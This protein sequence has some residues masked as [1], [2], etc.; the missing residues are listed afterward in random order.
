M[1]YPLIFSILI[2]L[3]VGS[4]L[5]VA[6][7]RVH[8]GEPIVKGRS[9]CRSCEEP[10]DAKDLVPVLSYLH[11]KGRC[12]RCKSVISWQYPVIEVA[13]M[14]LFVVAYLRLEYLYQ[15]GSISE[16]LAY[17]LVLRDWIFVAFL[18][19]IFV[20]DLRHMLIL[21]KF[22]V[23]GMIFAV[24]ANLLLGT[25]PVWSILAG[26]AVLAGFFWIQFLI[27]KGTWVGGGDIRMGALMG[28]MLGLEHGLVA[29]FIAY[30]LGAIM[31]L[32]M[33]ASGKVT[34]KTPVPFGT[35]LSVATI[36]MLFVGEPLIEWYLGL[37]L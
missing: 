8:E 16:G 34:R 32:A 3:C 21:D 35:F 28:F 9:K 17:L 27:S 29:L 31:G 12:R 11:L 14:L 5:N 37:F 15:I 30:V 6:I 20:Y 1:V 2:G 13:T 4:F 19:V 10:I 24:L 25:V 18:I 33:M 36:V 23:P 7:F 26:G 22:T